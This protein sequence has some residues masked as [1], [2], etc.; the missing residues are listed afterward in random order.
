MTGHVFPEILSLL[1]IVSGIQLMEKVEGFLPSQYWRDGTP[2]A[3]SVT[4]YKGFLTQALLGQWGVTF[5]LALLVVPV[6]QVQAFGG[7]S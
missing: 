1:S 5:Q 2:L 6:S 4:G 7:V 3:H